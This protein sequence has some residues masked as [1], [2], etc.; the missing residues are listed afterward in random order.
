MMALLVLFDLARSSVRLDELRPGLAASMERYRQMEGLLEK[1]YLSDDAGMFGGFYLFESQ[2]ALAAAL[3]QV[4]A[5]ATQRRI[6]VQP[7]ILT[8]D[9]E[10][11][12]ERR[13]DTPDRSVRDEPL[14]VADPHSL[15]YDATT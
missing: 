2:E 8:F 15:T 10:A 13:H 9:V 7:Q 14:P 12:L 3:P 1:V 4:R 5:T 11:I 6:G